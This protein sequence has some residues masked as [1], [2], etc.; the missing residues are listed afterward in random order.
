MS[1]RETAAEVKKVVAERIEQLRSRGYEPDTLKALV[2]RE[3]RNGA[4]VLAQFKAEHRAQELARV[5]QASVAIYGA[6]DLLGDS[7]PVAHRASYRDAVDRADRVDTPQQAERLLRQAERSGDELLARAVAVKA[8]ERNWADVTGAYSETRPEWA[9]AAENVAD[10]RVSVGMGAN[11]V[12]GMTKPDELRR[13]SDDQIDQFVASNQ[14][15]YDMA[16]N[17]APRTVSTQFGVPAYS[18]E[19]A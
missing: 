6:D 15:L 8:F 10:T 7:D 14:R 16:D 11:L 5:K 12:F 17:P 2:A 19:P 1:N 9:A 4:K 3:Y 18:G 13:M